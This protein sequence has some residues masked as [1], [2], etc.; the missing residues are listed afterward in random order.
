MNTQHPHL[1]G[2]RSK[3]DAVYEA[4]RQ[5]ILER[6]YAPGERLVI[7]K[8]AKE[9]GVSPIPVREAIRQLEADGLI[10]YTPNV[11]AVVTTIRQREY[12]EALTLLAVLEGYATACGVGRFAPEDFAQMEALNAA[13]EE[14]LEAHEYVRFSQLNR[15]FHAL[16]CRHCDN[17]TLL[18]RIARE[19]RR[20]DAFRPV[21]LPFVAGRGL[22]SVEE[23]R[24]IVRALA[25]GRD[26]VTV[27]MLVRQHKLNTIEAFRRLME[28]AALE[29]R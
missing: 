15:Q 5:R 29:L 18:D 22:R 12:I 11:G 8:I 3:T 2:K 24:A 25:E 13:M 26:A 1:H 6:S 27:E 23:H 19:Q 17:E 14:A 20:I 16:L 28:Q 9:F 7:D 10:Q 4:L 21:G